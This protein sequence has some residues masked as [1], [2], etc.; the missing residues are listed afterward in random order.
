MTS[1]RRLQTK[2]R[3]SATV[4]AHMTPPFAAAGLQGELADLHELMH[5]YKSMDIG[6][7]KKKDA[8]SRLVKNAWMKIFVPTWVGK[9]QKLSKTSLSS[10]PLY[11][12]IWKSLR[13]KINPLGLH[14]FGELPEQ[15]LTIS[16][17]AAD[18]G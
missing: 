2:R 13:R 16:T 7:V 18:V 4:I 8:A 3:G 5:Q 12:S 11:M 1:A 14:T 9:S 10:L 17:P 6:G 15:R